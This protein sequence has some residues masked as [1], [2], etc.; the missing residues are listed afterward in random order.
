MRCRP[1]LIRALWKQAGRF[2]NRH[3]KGGAQEIS[4]GPYLIKSD[5]RSGSSTPLVR[6]NLIYDKNGAIR[7]RL[8]LQREPEFG[9]GLPG[10]AP[11]S[12]GLGT[13]ARP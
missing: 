8:N 4:A 1:V 10:G 5:S 3:Y 6:Q 11:T 9:Q 7:P 13:S 12:L 2:E